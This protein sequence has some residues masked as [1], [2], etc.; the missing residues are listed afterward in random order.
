MNLNSKSGTTEVILKK[1]RI[2]NRKN[3]KIGNN[4]ITLNK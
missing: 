3:N 2:T 1:M 4:N